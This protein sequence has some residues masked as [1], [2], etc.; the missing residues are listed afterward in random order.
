M[1]LD[2]ILNNELELEMDDESNI[3]IPK[4]ATF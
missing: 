4:T 3:D 2:D 1:K